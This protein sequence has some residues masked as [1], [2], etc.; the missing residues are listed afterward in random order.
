MK[1]L[2]KLNCL[3]LTGFIALTALYSCQKSSVRDSNRIDNGAIADAQ[4]IEVALPTSTSSGS[5][6]AIFIIHAYAPGS[7]LDSVTFA[8]LPTAIGTYLT[9]NY[10]GYT[11]QKAYKIITAANVLNSYV[12]VIEFN[13]KPV[14]L[15]FDATGNFVSVLEQVE[16]RDLGGPF[17][18]PGGYFGY[19]D[20]MHRDTVAVSALPAAVKAYFTTNYPADTL[21]HA[22]LNVDGTYLVISADKGLFVTTVTAAGAFIKRIEVYPHPNNRITVAEADLLPVIT[23]YLTTTFPGYAFDKAFAE[24]ANTTVLEYDVFINVNG[25]RE[26]VVFDASGKFVSNIV[27]R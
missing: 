24:R 25:T 6:D 16:Q 13:G 12:V 2:T 1:R 10:A 3:L 21:L 27:I 9:A 5:T 8:S 11:F 19:R 14:G 20:G 23:T 26:V 17:W 15:K 7:K 22:D 4:A 18:H